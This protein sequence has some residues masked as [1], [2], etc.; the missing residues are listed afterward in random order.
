MAG[1]RKLQSAIF[2]T[3]G[4]NSALYAFEKDVLYSYSIP[5]FTT[6]VPGVFKWKLYISKKTIGHGGQDYLC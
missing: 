1:Y 5:V 6:K 2:E 4:Y 3:E